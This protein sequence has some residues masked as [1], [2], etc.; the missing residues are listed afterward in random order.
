MRKSVSQNPTL[1]VLPMILNQTRV[2]DWLTAT[3]PTGWA[4]AAVSEMEKL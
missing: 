2:L 1:I 4:T 3:T